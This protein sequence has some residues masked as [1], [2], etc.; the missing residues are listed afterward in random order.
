MSTFTT[1]D[2]LFEKLK[3]AWSKE[4]SGSWSAENPAK[5]QCSVTSLVV[6]DL[7]GG[8]ILKTKT[9]GGTHFYNLID[10]VRWD[11]TVSQFDYPIPF[12]DQPS[13]RDEAM[14]DTSQGQ[15]DALKFR[16]NTA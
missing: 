3:T 5:G 11:L 10:G 2:E 12:E 1:P 8:S 4:S 14:T 13:S 6:Q 15:Y 9:R 16:L 7:F